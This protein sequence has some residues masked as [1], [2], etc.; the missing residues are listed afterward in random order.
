[1]LG[2]I[3]RPLST[4]SVRINVQSAFYAAET[5]EGFL[6]AGF[7]P[8]GCAAVN[9]SHI[10]ATCADEVLRLRFVTCTTHTKESALKTQR[11][12]DVLV[13]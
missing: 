7:A 9:A 2:Y 12:A 1:M 11:R 6:V 10:P 3:P 8:S 4:G 13:D 5:P